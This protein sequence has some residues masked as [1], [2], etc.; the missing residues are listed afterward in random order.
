MSTVIC[1]K[2]V[3]QKYEVQKEQTE[4]MYTNCIGAVLSVD[5]RSVKMNPTQCPAACELRGYNRPSVSIFY[6]TA[7]GRLLVQRGR[8]QTLSNRDSA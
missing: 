8:N 5:R 6:F 4:T 1:L 7:R 2:N 3:S